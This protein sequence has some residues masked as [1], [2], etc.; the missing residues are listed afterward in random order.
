[1]KLVLVRHGQSEGNLKEEINDDPARVVNLTAQ[2]RIQ[3]A[4]A[5]QRLRG[6]AFTH[7]YASQFARAQQTAA[8]ILQGRALA[9]GVDARLNERRSGMDGQHVER[10]NGLVRADPL[11]TKPPH[12]E[13]FIEQMARLKRF[14]DEIAV[15][16][17]HGLVLAVSHEN[18]ILAA[19]ALTAEDPEAV[20]RGGLVNCEAV[21]LIWPA[22]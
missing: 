14:L 17:P 12:G 10:F 20:V 5:A 8:I 18:P 22:D 1:M 19:M 15:R 16:H 11:Q 6:M 13:S 4:R 21:E 3:A 9:L 2:G 7:A